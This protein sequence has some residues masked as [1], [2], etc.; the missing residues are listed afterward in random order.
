M[1]KEPLVTVIMSAYNA[2][3]HIESAVRSIMSQTYKNLEILICDDCSKDKTFGILTDLAAEDNRIS[4]IHNEMNLKLPK[5]LNKLID[6]AK[7]EFIARMDADDV[8]LPERIEKEVLFLLEHTDYSIVG[9]NAYRVLQNRIVGQFFV[10]TKNHDIQI[11]KNYLAVFIHPSVLIRTEVLKKYK[12]NES[13]SYTQDFELWQRLLKENK[14]AN[15]RQKL[16][17]YRVEASQNKQKI[18]LQSILKARALIEN[19][20]DVF[21]FSAR[22]VKSVSAKIPLSTHLFLTNRVITFPLFLFGFY[23][24]YYTIVRRY[25]KL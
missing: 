25:I 22:K 5:S 7:G 12:Y 20:V 4:I 17:Y 6:M 2:E 16:L 18:H 23:Y 9:T 11:L 13:Y 14:G 1:E 19:D 3:D 24:L 15:L 10:P 8:S 21:S